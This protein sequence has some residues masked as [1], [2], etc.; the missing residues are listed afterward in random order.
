MA[1]FCSEP[2][3]KRVEVAEVRVAVW[4]LLHAA[5]MNFQA[6][7]LMANGSAAMQGATS[8]SIQL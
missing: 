1:L 5:G 8:R 3:E 6:H 7:R 4:D 2:L